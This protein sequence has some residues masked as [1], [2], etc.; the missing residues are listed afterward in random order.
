M[1]AMP[2]PPLLRVCLWPLRRAVSIP[3]PLS[4]MLKVTRP[5]W[6]AKSTL[7]LARLRVPS[8]V[9]ERFLGDAEEIRLGLIG[10]A[11]IRQSALIAHGDARALGEAFGQGA[12]RG[13]DTKIV[14]HGGAEQ[15]RHLAHIVNGL[16][17]QMHA[18]VYARGV[19][20]GA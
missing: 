1:P 10:Q 19:I 8:D 12:E 7:H 15:L 20:L 16:I 5:F 2:K 18:I 4:R 17:D 14:K 11:L 9:G 6:R 13:I 3:L